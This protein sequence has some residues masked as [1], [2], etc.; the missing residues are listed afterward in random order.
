MQKATNSRKSGEF[1]W[2]VL[3]KFNSKNDR[4]CAA[5]KTAV[6]P[7]GLGLLCE[8]ISQKLL[9]NEMPAFCFNVKHI[10]LT[11]SCNKN[12]IMVWP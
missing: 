11:Q 12:K 9:Q 1:Y 7:F 8:I 3:R 10:N 4:I 5:F 2:L 6:D